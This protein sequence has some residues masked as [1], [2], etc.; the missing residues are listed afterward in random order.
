MQIG[1][2]S[3][4][5][6]FPPSAFC[7]PHPDDADLMKMMSMMARGPGLVLDVTRVITR[8]IKRTWTPDIGINY[9]RF[10]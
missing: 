3:N 6:N 7:I 9:P 2:E 1:E 4:Q 10:D 8:A 5:I